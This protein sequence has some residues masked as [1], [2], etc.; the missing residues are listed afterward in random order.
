MKLGMVTIGQSPRDDIVPFMKERIGSNVTILQQGALD[1]LD[2]EELHALIPQ[3]GQSQL[4]TRLADGR[5]IVISKEKILPLV[6]SRITQLNQQDVGLVVL[7]CTGKF[8]KFKSRALLVSAQEIVDHCLA[9]VVDDRYTLG[10]VSPLEEQMEPMRQSLL[11]ITPRIAVSYC[12]PYHKYVDM[13]EAAYALKDQNPDIVIL[14][15]MG[16]NHEHRRAIRKVLKIPV[17][18]ASSIVS[19]TVAELLED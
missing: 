6:Q 5:Q 17:I 12:S 4:C 9:A 19:R 1:G 7:L 8:P 10:L 15:C 2:D 13:T 18:I 3:K 11:H 16:F 14:H